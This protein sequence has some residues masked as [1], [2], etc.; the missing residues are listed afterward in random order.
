MNE[1]QRQQTFDSCCSYILPHLANGKALGHTE[2]NPHTKE[3]LFEHFILSEGFEQFDAGKGMI[4]D[5]SSSFLGLINVEDHIHIHLFEKSTNW[6]E[7]YHRLN[8]LDKEISRSM[9][10]AFS[11]R[12]G[13]LTSDP[14]VCGTGL[15]VQTFLHCPALIH[16]G[17][18]AKCIESLGKDIIIRGLGHED[19]YIS[20][21]ILIENKFKLGV[22]EPDILKSIHNAAT[23]LAAEE[24]NAREALKEEKH[25]HVKDLICRAYAILKHAHTLQIEE[26]LAALSLFE[27]GKQLGWIEGGD[28][29]SFGKSFFTTRR[30]HLHEALKSA[31]QIPKE[32]LIVKRAA[33]IHEKLKS[34]NINL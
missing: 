28:D 6:D 27:L 3:F 21:L 25:S 29:L 30:A 1:A 17:N 15:V 22:T 20:D 9:E 7:A 26:T 19:E 31:E 2:L 32:D 34:S 16:T 24:K 4:I 13:H 18:F 8:N 11:D 12:F 23:K 14:L 10:F 33:L 5:D